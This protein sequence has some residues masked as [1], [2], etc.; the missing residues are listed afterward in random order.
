MAPAPRGGPIVDLQDTD[1]MIFL[2]KA[3]S[4]SHGRAR[5]L[6]AASVSVSVLLAVC[7][8]VATV[9]DRLAV[10]VTVMGAL[11]AIG[12]GAGLAR[13]TDGE[14]VRA[15]TLQEM[16]DVRLFR[17]PWNVIVAG[18]P[19]GVAEVSWLAHR[20]RGREADLY[21]YYEVPRLRSPY[22]VVACQLQNLAWGARVRGRYARVLL[23]AVG[24]W[25]VA[26]VVV[27]IVGG[28]T[29][30]DTVL[31][32]F[33]PSLGALLLAWDSFRTQREVAGER[34]RVMAILWDQVR[35]TVTGSGEVG[36][37]VELTRQV[38][39]A[40]LRTRRRNIRVPEWFFARFREV[41]RRDFQAVVAELS[42]T[43]DRSAVASR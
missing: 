35:R 37:L 33:V 1:E 11:W 40:I 36:A 43:V 3:V 26:G 28:L 6:D 29:V 19:I 22:D 30:T 34:Q 32:W 23:G 20:F 31:R 9:V 39:D 24:L 18:E 7:G 25:S 2:L 38:Q 15:A 41:D 10:P 8:L 17:L 4:V 14:L 27:G 5:R 21:G 12:Y 13:W 16:F 42:R